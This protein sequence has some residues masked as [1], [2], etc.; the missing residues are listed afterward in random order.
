MATAAEA[1]L[2][3]IPHESHVGASWVTLDDTFGAGSALMF[4]V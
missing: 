1:I 2:F 3:T 4:P